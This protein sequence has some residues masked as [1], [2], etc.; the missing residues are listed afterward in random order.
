LGALAL[1][2][3]PIVASAGPI[4][5]TDRDAFL[6]AANPNRLEAFDGP[7][8]CFPDPFTL[9]AC[10]ASYSVVVFYPEASFL[11]PFEEVVPVVPTQTRIGLPWGTFAV[12]LD[13]LLASNTGFVIGFC[14]YRFDGLSEPFNCDAPEWSVTIPPGEDVNAFVGI[15]SPDER[16]WFTVAYASAGG[17]GFL[18]EPPQAY[19]YPAVVDNLVTRVPEPATAL[20]VGLGIVGAC[21]RGRRTN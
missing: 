7:E 14:S 15:V 8:V 9:G 17:A 12:G 1:L 19:G 4:L 13:L 2:L 11:D 21:W 6:A 3:S 16:E 5:F 10:R 18:R 20:L